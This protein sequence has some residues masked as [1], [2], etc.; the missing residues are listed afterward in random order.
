MILDIL[1]T[2]IVLILLTFAAL[3]KFKK[4]NDTT[5]FLSREYGNWIKG[6]CAIIVI[7]VH[8]SKDYQNPFQDAIGSFAFVAVTFFFFF[9]AY[10]MQFNVE[11]NKGY[12]NYFWRNKLVSL[13]VPCITFNIVVFFFT[14]FR[15]GEWNFQRLY[16]INKY[17][18]VLLEYCVWFFL[19]MLL[20]KYKLISNKRI[21][22]L[23]LIAGVLL[24]SLI[25][26]FSKTGY[27]VSAQI[28][29]CYERW[30]LIWGLL[31][32][33]YFDPLLIWLN[34]RRAKKT[35][36]FLVLSLILGLTYLKYKTVWFSGEYCLKIVLGL[37]II[38]FVMLLTQKRI[39][40]NYISTVLGNA[41]YEIFLSHGF[42]MSVLTFYFPH[43]PSGFFIVLTILL[44]IILSI[45][46][47]ALNKII[48]GKLRYNYKK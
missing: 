30:G 40:G 19:I 5:F 20:V 1:L 21:I 39:F 37:V 11:K 29:W 47:H 34:N 8:F 41:S 22:D 35:I 14:Y 31:F 7:M 3:Y 2:A 13:L 38:T 4:T 25:Y 36:I 15:T 12:L 27:V 9:S 33:R 32:Y 43:L 42:I 18:R 16:W 10:G 45:P 48:V 26:Y 44:T 46:L 17:V 28:G 24:S 23:L 6:L